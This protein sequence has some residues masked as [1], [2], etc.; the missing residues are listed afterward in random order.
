MHGEKMEKK[1]QSLL[2]KIVGENAS[3]PSY[4][5]VMQKARKQQNNTIKNIA[6]IFTLPTLLA[7]LKQDKKLDIVHINISLAKCI[8]HSKEIRNHAKAQQHAVLQLAEEI[9]RI[10]Q[11]STLTLTTETFNK[12]LTLHAALQENPQ[13]MEMLIDHMQQSNIQPDA[14]T[15]NIMIQF[16]KK[17][18]DY[19]QAKITF[20]TMQQQKIEPDMHL[21]NT[22]L[23][24]YAHTKDLEAVWSLV[25]VIERKNLVKDTCTYN[26]LIKLYAELNEV[27]NALICFEEMKKQGI[28]PDHVSYHTLMNMFAKLKQAEEVVIMYEQMLAH[29]CKPKATT[30]N[31][32]L[33][34]YR[35]IEQEEQFNNT[36][37]MLKAQSLK[38]NLI[39]YSIMIDYYCRAQNEVQAHAIIDEMGKRNIAPDHIIYNTLITMY[40]KQC[41][42]KKAYDVFY[43]IKT[44]RDYKID[45]AIY[46]NMLE[47]TA[48]QLDG[49]ACNTL[50]Y[51]AIQLHKSKKSRCYIAN[52]YIDALYHLCK[53]QKL[54]A[55]TFYTQAINEYTSYMHDFFVAKSNI[56]DCHGMSQGAFAILLIDLCHKQSAQFTP[57]LNIGKGLHSRGKESHRLS[58]VPNQL[59]TLGWLQHKTAHIEGKYMRLIDV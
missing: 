33:A 21:Y 28:E 44:S 4:E 57:L 37:Q 39:T 22:M 58:A 16:Y 27:R 7:Q 51:E 50:Y 59:K 38:P 31:I 36:L 47:I 23:D 43:K 9:M 12:L 40:K 45:K 48:L 54:T 35:D 32:L 49:Q 55:E 1:Y 15:Y 29:Q 11:E 6:D 13:S 20:A 10:G 53:Q 8:E 30:Y 14:I 25:Q 46:N 18:G 5:V 2:Q 41:N 56:I 19:H 26:T 17:H 24:V 34:L 3:L 42:Y 52:S